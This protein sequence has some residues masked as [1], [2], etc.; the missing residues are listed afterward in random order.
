MSTKGLDV[1]PR[2]DRLPSSALQPNEFSLQV[3]GDPD[4]ET[5]G[6]LESIRAH[7]VL[8]PLVVVPTEHGWEIL[9]GHRRLACARLLNLPEVPCEVREVRTRAARRLAVLEYNRQRHK[10]FSQIMREADAL[11]TLYAA[12][13]RRRRE[14]NLRQFRDGASGSS[15]ECRNSDARAGR[16]DERIARTVGLGG[17]DLYRQARAVWRV[18]STAD[19]RA[20]SSLTQLDAGTKTIHAA[21]KDLRRRD[22]FTAGFRPTPYDVWAFKHDR[23]FGIPHP[24]SIPPSIVAHALHYFTA[25]GALVVDP[26]A[27]GGTTLDVCA[28][29]GRRCLAYDLHPVRSDIRKHDV[30][31]GFPPE[32]SGCDLVFCDPPY[33]TML[34]RRYAVDGAAD[35]PLTAWVDFLRGLAA[36]CQDALRPGGFVALLLATQTEKDLPAGFGYIDHAV[37]GYN[38]L[39]GAGFIPQRRISCPMD[40]AYLPQHV[41]RARAEGRM[42]G[43]VRDLLVMR[44]SGPDGRYECGSPQA[45]S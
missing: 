23:A 34:A 2:L 24:G 15:T 8:V 28:S 22:R 44:K 29:M 13:G 5:D 32:A 38:A 6:L 31:G 41:R 21:Y 12:E 20:R 42:L 36:C 1:R 43:Q 11:E 7:G 10:T 37:L 16:T 39:V 35:V 17:K 27:G 19:P 9:S 14:A 40:G 30:N 26:M 4:T 3:Y 18:A 25:P 33:H 45:S